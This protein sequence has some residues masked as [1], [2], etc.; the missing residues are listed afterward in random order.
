[1]ALREILTSAT[2]T[3]AIQGRTLKGLNQSE[4][5]GIYHRPGTPNSTYT[6]IIEQ[7]PVGS[8]N[9]DDWRPASKPF[10]DSSIMEVM[11]VTEAFEYRANVSTLSSNGSVLIIIG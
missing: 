3:K 4:V 6:F 1:M 5:I 9:P 7:R 11:R 8:A 2:A 10:A